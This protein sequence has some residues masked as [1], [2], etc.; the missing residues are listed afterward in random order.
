M[1]LNY[2]DICQN[3]YL[4]KFNPKTPDF[5]SNILITLILIYHDPFLKIKNTISDYIDILSKEIDFIFSVAIITCNHDISNLL[6][7]NSAHINL[8]YISKF[9][10][11]NIQI[12]NSECFSFVTHSRNKTIEIFDTFFSI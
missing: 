2:L 7:R 5:N 3:K 4:M 11:N 8:K 1:G 6:I 12:P 10:L 9:T